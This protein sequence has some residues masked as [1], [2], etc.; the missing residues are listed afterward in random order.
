MSSLFLGTRVFTHGSALAG[1]GISV[2]DALAELAALTFVFREEAS[3]SDENGKKRRKK[4]T[5]DLFFVFYV[6]AILS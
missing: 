3:T 5:L 4:E 2:D 6:M 1:T